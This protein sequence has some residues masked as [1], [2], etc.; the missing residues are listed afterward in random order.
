MWWDPS[1][2]TLEVEE[3]AALRHQRILEVDADKTAAD[4]SEQD[5]AAWKRG[6]T[7]LLDPGL[8]ALDLRPDGHCARS[9]GSL[10]TIGSSPA[11]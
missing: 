4:E 1:A 10:S 6:R 7:D 11:C 5:Y 2:L 3:H 8:S 9:L